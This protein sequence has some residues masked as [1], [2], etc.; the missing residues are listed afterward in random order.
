MPDSNATRPPVLPPFFAATTRVGRWLAANARRRIAGI[1][2]LAVSATIAAPARADDVHI[3]IDA[4]RP[5]IAVSPHLY[6][7]NNSL[8][9]DPQRPL[10]AAEW[11]RL[12]DAGVRLLREHGGNNGTKY[13][14]QKKLSS[15]PDWYNNVYAHDWDFAQQSLQEHL[16]GVQ[17]LWCFQLLG[18]VA[19]TTAQNFD[20]WGFNRSQWWAGTGQNLAGGGVPNTAGGSVAQRDGSPDR[21][22]VATSAETSTA[23]LDHWIG[24]AGLHLDRSQFRY[25][26]MDN[27][28]EI[29]HSTHDDVGAPQVP[30]E[31]FMQRYFAYAVQ[32]RARFPEIK[33]LG[34]VPAN[35]WQWYNYAEPI[36]ADGRRFCWLEYFIKRIGEE[37]ARTGVRLL[38]VLDLH[39]YPGVTNPA[40][41]VQLHRIFFEETYVNPEANGVHAVDGGWD[42]TIN[43]EYVFARCQRWLDQYLGRNHGVTFGV[44]ETGTATEDVPTNS[45]WYASLLGEFMKRGV[46]VLTPW[47]WRPGMWEVLH[48]FSRYNHGIY[49]SAESDDETS[50]S[51]YPT[52]DPVS[53][54]VTVVLVNRSLASPKTV[55]TAIGGVAVADGAYQTLQLAGL[56]PT[57]TFVTHENNALRRGAVAVAGG[58]FSVT[59]PP[60]SITSV[61]LAAP[62][63]GPIPPTA[64]S[65]L[66]NLSV[67]ARSGGGDEVLI[68]GL[69]IAGAGNKQVV[70][71]GIGPT[72]RSMGVSA[73]LADPTLT[74]FDR[75]GTELATNDQW[76][77]A[78]ALASLFG[79]LGA[80][81]LEA[82][83]ADAALAPSL[84]SGGYTFHVRGKTGGQGVA[85]GEV[86]EVDGNPGARL[87]NVAARTWV[88]TS[89]DVLIA[90]F[91]ITGGTP[92]KVLLRAIGPGLAG[93]GVSGVLADPVLRL[94][95][96]GVDTPIHQNNDWG[97]TSYAEEIES[98]ASRIGAFRMAAGSRDAT[99]LLSLP[100]GIYSAMVLGNNGTT[101]VGMVEVYDAD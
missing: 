63:P 46:E 69:V 22:L 78:P 91:V 2:V 45:I 93:Q 56:P 9:D 4:S 35:E 80:F 37:Q 40:D 10:S 42:T 88:G 61:L 16:P 70:L 95:R 30:A 20:D 94:Y 7:R 12:R 71:R 28:P 66:V 90:G 53:G 36:V 99:L 26:N 39:Y 77:G 82:G 21:Y 44:T 38:D 97:S 79:A 50:V 98:T 83:S 59:L 85:L 6:G 1:A 57:E 25:W 49:L 41:I 86:Y 92:K 33:L 65:R 19:D 18:R 74:L 34:P 60:L 81:Q 55:T 51:A 31:A 54:G 100:P 14:W 87:V 67:R 11:Q 101:G 17:G 32:A 15:H 62:A 29:W 23:I 75:H 13:N 84:S 48:L 43:R 68:V 27:E 5:R 73:P 58:R 96:Y 3:T 8:S 76:G 64:P 89:D 72:L 52:L 24:S 47:N